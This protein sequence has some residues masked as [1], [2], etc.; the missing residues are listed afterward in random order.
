MSVGAFLSVGPG[1]D[2]FLA[3]FSLQRLPAVLGQWPCH[4]SPFLWVFFHLTFP[5]TLTLCLPLQMVLVIM[6][7]LFMS[8]RIN[9]IIWFHLRS[10]LCQCEALGSQVPGDGT[11]AVDRGEGHYSACTYN[12]FAHTNVQPAHRYKVP[13]SNQLKLETTPVKIFWQCKIVITGN[14][15]R[16]QFS[17]WQYRYLRKWQVTQAWHIREN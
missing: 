4:H 13:A 5:L 8:S 15:V 9:S 2:Y 6:L 12:I 11:W 1:R 10:F 14:S 16:G 3:L 7:G 17:W